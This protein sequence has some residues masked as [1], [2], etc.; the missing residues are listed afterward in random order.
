MLKLAYSLVNLSSMLWKNLLY[1]KNLRILRS[2]AYFVTRR[3][4]RSLVDLKAPA[5]PFS[6]DKSIKEVGM[7]LIRSIKN[8]PYI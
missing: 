1:F 2:L 3:I 6:W 7:L 4:L 8:Q 5:P